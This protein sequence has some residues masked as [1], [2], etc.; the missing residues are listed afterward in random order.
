MSENFNTFGLE[1]KHNTTVNTSADIIQQ[2]HVLYEEYEKTI[3]ELFDTKDS[4]EKSNSEQESLMKFYQNLKE[5]LQIKLEESDEY[6][7]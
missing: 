1:N 7:K 5:Q 6:I 2:Y 4:L 3:A